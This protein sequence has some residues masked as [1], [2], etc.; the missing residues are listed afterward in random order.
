MIAPSDAA[1]PL[2]KIPAEGKYSGLF[3]RTDDKMI[4]NLVPA[5]FTGWTI[6]VR[7]RR[8][9]ANWGIIIGNPST[10][11]WVNGGFIVNRSASGVAYACIGSY[12]EIL[13][14]GDTSPVAFQMLL[15]GE[16]ATLFK[17][18]LNGVQIGSGNLTQIDSLAPISLGGTSVIGDPDSFGGYIF[19]SIVINRTDAAAIAAIEGSL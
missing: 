1:R 10:P 9:D 6:A 18:R 2:L 5:N 4:S 19:D 8:I 16:S 3:T 11:G 15:I 13:P 17:T 14:Y 7:A 12:T